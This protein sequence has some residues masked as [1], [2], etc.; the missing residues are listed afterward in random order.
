MDEASVWNWENNRYPPRFR[1]LPKIIAFLGY[2]PQYS[3]TGSLAEK[4]VTSRRLLSLSQKWLAGLLEINPST[5]ASA[6]VF[7]L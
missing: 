7:P 3:T 2:M 1:S 6:P 5:L 4:L